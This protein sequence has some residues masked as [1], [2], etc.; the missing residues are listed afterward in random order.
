MNAP[1]ADALLLIGVLSVFGSVAIVARRIVESR[2]PSEPSH[3]GHH[4]PSDQFPVFHV[5]RDTQ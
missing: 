2:R 1:T 3:W 4:V 5:E